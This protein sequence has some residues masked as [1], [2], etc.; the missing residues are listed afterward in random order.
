MSPRRV[1]L[2]SAV[3]VLALGGAAIAWWRS[4]PPPLQYET[5]T[6]D[7][8]LV[9]QK[10]V[11]R[12]ELSAPTDTWVGSSVAGRV[13]KI[14][15]GPNAR[16]TRGRVMARVEPLGAQGVREQA[17]T[18]HEAARVNVEKTRDQLKRAEA[19]LVRA[20]ALA[21]KKQASASRLD[22]S[23]ATV[24]L[25]KAAVAA[26]EALEMQAQVTMEQAELDF[27]NSVIRAP[28]NGFVVTQALQVGQLVTAAD[29][30]AH[31]FGLATRVETLRL[32]VKLP[33]AGAVTLKPGAYGT[34]S[35]EGA[36]GQALRATVKEVLPPEGGDGPATVVLDADN[37]DGSLE[38]GMPATLT[39]VQ[40][41]RDK[42][43]RLPNP[44]VGFQPDASVK[45]R[46]P[47][48]A[49]TSERTTVWVVDADDRPVQR[50]VVL[51]IVDPGHTEVVG[52][53]LVA[54]DRVITRAWTSRD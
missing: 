23:R 10:V 7:E 13:A 4:R 1:L 54:G 30:K 12:G 31:F 25:A 36:Q 3:L 14:E 42:T 52:G 17:K 15:V 44:A 21:K 45:H 19:E 34:L 24:E 39:I 9:E 35:V 37:P 48:V 49:D 22:I 6:V 46:F 27:S 43:L 2:V 53:S 51:G 16:V 33:A 5:V 38:P 28:A 20:Q 29:R 11:A 40:A 26:A 47:S 18:N 50:A 41:R 32:E 8:G